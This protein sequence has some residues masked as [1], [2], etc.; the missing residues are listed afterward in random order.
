MKIREIDLGQ[1]RIAL[2]DRCPFISYAWLQGI[3]ESGF[4]TAHEDIGLF[5]FSDGSLS[6]NTLIKR[7]LEAVI[8]LLPP[9]YGGPVLLNRMDPISKFDATRDQ[10]FFIR[11]GQEENCIQFLKRVDL[12]Y[13]VACAHCRRKGIRPGTLLSFM[14]EKK[15]PWSNPPAPSKAAWP[16]WVRSKS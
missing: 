2:S 9:A 3:D 7:T 5:V 1:L 4:I 14:G 8:A 15:S 12:D 11:A 10:P 6:T 16:S 13:R